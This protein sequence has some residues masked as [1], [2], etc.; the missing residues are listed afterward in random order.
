[1]S[2]PCAGDIH[3]ETR[4]VSAYRDAQAAHSA[5][6]D[7]QQRATDSW[8]AAETLLQRASLMRDVAQ[9]AVHRADLVLVGM[10]PEIYVEPEAGARP[11]LMW[12]T[13]RNLQVALPDGR[14]VYFLRTRAG[15]WRSECQQL[16]VSDDNADAAITALR[17]LEAS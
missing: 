1:M 15:E 17:A 3:T 16:R 5:A 14:R 13:E 12:A 9:E 6:L 11:R 8:L 4:T 7:A 2:F 10:H